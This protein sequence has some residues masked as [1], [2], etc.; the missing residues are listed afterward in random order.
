MR[1]TKNFGK[2][3]LIAL[4]IV[5]GLGV[6]AGANVRFEHRIIDD[7]G[8]KDPWAKIIADIDGDGKPDV[9]VGGRNGPLVW[10]AWPDWSMENITHSTCRATPTIAFF[11]EP[12]FRC[13]RS[14]ILRHRV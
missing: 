11:F 10:Y 13:N 12:V 8:P 1:A 9:I 14:N 5:V 7:K 6:S 4:V 2:G 3:L